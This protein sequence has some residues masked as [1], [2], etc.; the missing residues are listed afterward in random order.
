MDDIIIFI[1]ICPTV[2]IEVLKLYDFSIN[3]DGDLQM[4][5]LFM[6]VLGSSMSETAGCL[7]L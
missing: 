6:L 1:N 5:R 7:I 2:S 3:F 4:A